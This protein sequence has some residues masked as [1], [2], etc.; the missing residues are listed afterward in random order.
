MCP[1]CWAR[2]RNDLKFFSVF[3]A[4]KSVMDFVLESVGNIPDEPRLN[5]EKTTGSPILNLFI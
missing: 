2:P 3:G 1:N 5:P 4:G